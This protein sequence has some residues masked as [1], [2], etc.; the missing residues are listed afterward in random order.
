M[1]RKRLIF[2]LGLAIALLLIPNIKVS[3][4]SESLVH[5]QE[6]LLESLNNKDI[7]NIVLANDINTT[8]K[9]NITRKVT[10]DGSNHTLKYVGTFG[11]EKSSDNKIWSG[12]YLIQV[13]KT[14]VTVKDIKLTGGNAAILVNGGTVKL[15]GNIDVSGNGF[16]GI[17]LSQGKGVTNQSRMIIDDDTNLVNTTET[18]T[19]PTMWVPSDSK[20]AVVEMAGILKTVKKGEELSLIEIENLFTTENPETSDNLNLLALFGLSGLTLFYI[21]YKNLKK[22]L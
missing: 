21:S 22:E 7:T 20:D 2:L 15:L 14:I 1:L 5:N 12:I 4:Q 10:I 3:A 13:Y 8:Q 9:I 11:E 6:E 19:T 16:G 18:S 17:E